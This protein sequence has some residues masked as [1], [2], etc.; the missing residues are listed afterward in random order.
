MKK[1]LY[2]LL[3]LSL[4]L[5]YSQLDEGQR[6]NFDFIKVE[7]EN[8]EEYESFITNYIGKV[9]ET[10]V[11]NGQYPVKIGHNQNFLRGLRPSPP[12]EPTSCGRFGSALRAREVRQA[13]RAKTPQTKTD[14][15]CLN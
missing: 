10:A 13:R 12:P 6:I 11:E 3:V 2:T 7:K 9:A 14:F 5:S 15:S 4:S 8:I 1:I